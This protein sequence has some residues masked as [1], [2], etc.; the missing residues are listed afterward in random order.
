MVIDIN[1]VGSWL[2]PLLDPIHN[3]SNYDD[4]SFL[5]QCISNVS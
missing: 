4:G 5:F 3:T 2:D 1:K